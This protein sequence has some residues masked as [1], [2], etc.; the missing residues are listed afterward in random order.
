MPT[1]P[2]YPL[3]AEAEHK[4]QIGHRI[5]MVRIAVGQ[6]QAE[7]RGEFG[8]KETT[9]SEW[10]RGSNF[11]KPP[12]L[13]ALCSAYRLTMDYFYRGETAGVGSA[14]LDKL[15]VSESSSGLAKTEPASSTK[16]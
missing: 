8:V 4:R 15:K 5:R 12:F 10:E 13:V 9:I 3:M 2:R 14:M 11:A 1:E 6:T 16:R 7:W